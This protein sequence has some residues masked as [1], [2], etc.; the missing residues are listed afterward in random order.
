MTSKNRATYGHAGAKE[1]VW[2]KAK[3]IRGMDPDTHRQDPY[4]NQMYYHS[5]GKD[6]EQGWSL[7]HIR[8]SSR[9]GSNDII[10]LQAMNFA[11]NRD[12]SNTTKKRSR[13]NQK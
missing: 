6:T 4:G 12:L 13:H 3:P 8:P 1:A 11:T 10:N 5:Y 9:G 2:D 7:D